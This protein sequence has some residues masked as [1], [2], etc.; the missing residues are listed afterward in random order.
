MALILI[1]EDEETIATMYKFK[2]EQQGFKVISAVNGKEGLDKAR[3][4]MPDLILLDLMMPEMNGDVMLARIRSQE[5]GSDMRVIVLT[6]ISRDEAPASI[7]LLGID[8][9]IVKAHTTPAQISDIVK[10]VLG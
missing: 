5:W 8:R 6:N 9:F 10:E 4:E 7:R 1:V 2:L 3:Y